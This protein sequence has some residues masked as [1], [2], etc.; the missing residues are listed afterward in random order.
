MTYYALGGV[1]SGIEWREDN[2]HTLGRVFLRQVLGN[3]RELEKSVVRL[4]ETGQGVQPNYQVTF[5][6]GLVRTLR[7]SSHKAFDQTE[8]FNATRISEPFTLAQVRNAYERA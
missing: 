6:N 3:M 2:L 4:G 5:P 1:V 7:G 8:E